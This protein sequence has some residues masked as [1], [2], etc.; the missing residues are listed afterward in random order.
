[1]AP[2]RARIILLG[3]V[4]IDRAGGLAPAILTGRRAEVVFAYLAIEGH[5]TVS[6]DELATVLWPDVL[7]D[8]WNAALR[9]VLSDVRRFLERGGLDPADVLRTEQGRLRLALPP[10]ATVD[11]DQTRSD[12]AEARAA[13]A[14]DDASL[15]AQLATRAAD[16]A[17]LPFLSFLDGDW[18]DGVRM[19]L[20]RRHV[21]ALALAG[22]AYAKAGD[23]RAALGAADRLVRADPFL[24]SA[25]RLR[26]AMLGETGDRAGALKAYER[27]KALL[28]SE[29]GIEPAPETANMLR[30]ALLWGAPVTTRQAGAS[31][32]QA[33]AAAV[34]LGLSDVSVLVVEDH[35]FQRRTTLTLLRGLGVGVL[36]EASDGA[37]ALAILDDAAAPDVIICDIDMPGMDGVEFIR[38]VAE[39]R[40]ASAVIFASGLDERVLETVR[41]ASEGYG[42]PVLGA[43]GKPLTAAALKGMLGRYRQPSAPTAGDPGGTASALTAAL[44][45]GTLA[46]RFEPVVDLRVGR[47]A[48]FR[49]TVDGDAAMRL[50]PDHAALGR[51]LAEH[52]LVAARDACTA[53]DLDVY[54]DLAPSVLTD[55]AL[56]DAL[57]AIAC[58]RV[59]LVAGAT[60][61]GLESSPAM[62]DVLA[63][64]RV[65]GY[66]LCIDG[67]HVGVLDRLPWTHAQ[68]PG[69]LIAAAAAEDDPAPLQP[70]VDAARALG[71]PM[72]G[73]AETSHQFDLLLQVGCSFALGP[74]LAPATTG[75]RLAEVARDWVAPAVTTD[76]LR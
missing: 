50:A 41:A 12:L 8:T 29:L 73:R 3:R 33:P 17:A 71:L 72:I 31:A 62:F 25:H 30:K 52:L 18:A 15:A 42:L 14:A 36:Q 65:K 11:V 70:A 20:D 40:L 69:E 59:V 53:L 67:P 74:F 45:A 46:V 5:R 28:A 23:P 64:L 61:L 49:A 54:V 21:D 68:L 56:A 76:P 22:E 10:T 57:A 13:L 6:R 75:E 51:R 9:G 47:V 7:P 19:D 60:A 24:E 32:A 35:D 1:M 63:R 26:I 34:E 58:R 4:A 2:D 16:A 43:V 48:G 37:A 39:R 44:D 38:N 66:G 27:C 55:V